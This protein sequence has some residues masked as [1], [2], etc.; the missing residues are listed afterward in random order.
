MLKLCIKS[1]WPTL[2]FYLNTGQVRPNNTIGDIMKTRTKIFFGTLAAVLVM[3]APLAVEARP[4]GH[5]GQQM[6]YV[7]GGSGMHWGGWFQSLTPEKQQTISALFKA[8]RAKTQPIREQLWVKNTTLDALSPNPK[9]VG[10]EKHS[11]P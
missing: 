6:G 10:P 11:T 9:V 4:F 8:H 3:S 2:C 7:E 1:I 5:G